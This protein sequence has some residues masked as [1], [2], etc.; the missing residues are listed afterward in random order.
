MIR[1][2][3]LE[4]LLILSSK[5]KEDYKDKQKKSNVDEMKEDENDRTTKKRNY[6]MFQR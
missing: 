1:N 2:I 5:R 3:K 6:K 4:K